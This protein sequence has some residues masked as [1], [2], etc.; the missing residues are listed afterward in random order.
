VVALF[1]RWLAIRDELAKLKEAGGVCVVIDAGAV[2]DAEL[3]GKKFGAVPAEEVQVDQVAMWV[4]AHG[5]FAGMSGGRSDEHG[6]SLAGRLIRQAARWRSE[7]GRSLIG[8]WLSHILFLL[9]GSNVALRSGQ[10]KDELRWTLFVLEQVRRI[11]E[12]GVTSTTSCGARGCYLIA[13][14]ETRKIRTLKREGC[15]THLPHKCKANTSREDD[16]IRTL[17]GA[18]GAPPTC[19][20]KAKQ[21]LLVKKGACLSPDVCGGGRWWWVAHPSVLR[22][23]N[24]F[25]LWVEIFVLLVKAGMKSAPL[26]AK[27]A[28]PA[29]DRKR[30]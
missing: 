17:D 25:A 8:Y 26:T 13:G 19:Y 28:P 27:H 14:S 11:T 29:F 21:T 7:L 9:F 20:T 2:V 5:A 23:R 3:A 22:V 12:S 4:T 18:K 30:R 6:F 24:C 1:S 10:W 16:K 15:A